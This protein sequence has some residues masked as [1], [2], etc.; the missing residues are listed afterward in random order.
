LLARLRVALRHAHGE[1]EP[2]K[3]IEAAGL[4]ID[5]E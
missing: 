3:Q 4:V 1:A 5:L 2:R